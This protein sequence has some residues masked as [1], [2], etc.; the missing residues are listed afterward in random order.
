[1]DLVNHKTYLKWTGSIE[2]PMLIEMVCLSG[3]RFIVIFSFHFL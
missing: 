3:S 1:M 2:R